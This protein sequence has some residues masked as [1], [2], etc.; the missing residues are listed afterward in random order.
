[1]KAIIKNKLTGETIPVTST[2]DHPD[3]SY[4]QPVWVDS[5]F[6]AYCVVGFE[7]P[8]FEVVSMSVDDAESLAMM[9]RHLRAVKGISIREL[10]EA[11]EVSK[12]TI[13]NVESG[14]FSPRL[15]ILQRILRHLGGCIEIKGG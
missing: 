4:G 2:T 15:D 14:N 1:M 13:V 5:N 6:D 9:V 12:T 3:S 11:C 7:Q 10:A 8:L